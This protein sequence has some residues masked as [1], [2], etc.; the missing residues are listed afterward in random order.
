MEKTKHDLVVEYIEGLA[1]GDKVSVRQLAREMSISEGTVYRAIKDAENQGLVSS[2]PKVGTIRIERVKERSIDS[3]TY[4]ELS[5]IV[6][7]R[8]LSGAS[9]NKI[10]PKK[11]YVV[12]SLEQLKEKNLRP[13]TMIVCEYDA[14]VV[15]YAKKNELA[16]LLTGGSELSQEQVLLASLDENQIVIST[17]YDIFD[18]ISAINQA[19]VQRVQNRELITIADI[20]TTDPYVLHGFDTV[21]DWRELSAQTGH[22]RFP[23]V[24]SNGKLEGVVTSFDVSDA[25]LATYIDDVMTLNPVVVHSDA[26]V[27]YL[28]RLLVLEKVDLVPVVDAEGILL[29]VVGRKDVIEAQQTM[30]KQPHLGDT[31]DYIIMSGFSIVARDPDVII[32]GRVTPYMLDECG[33]LSLG[34]CNVLAANTAGIMLR[35][36][37]N[38]QGQ[39]YQ[40]YT[41]FFQQIGAEEELYVMPML[42]E[43]GDR[44]HVSVRIELADGQLAA[45]SEIDFLVKDK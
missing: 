31:S 1:V 9:H 23:V 18:A 13:S 36:K 41:H 19:I 20:M 6:E 4:D 7:G 26:L 15:A 32:S 34:V 5:K 42:S 43:H 12:T 35:I 28:G 24:D 40:A 29:G 8:F 39:A 38:I 11:F 22:S 25:S 3:L 30:Q 17:P 33:G 10:A 37:K 16:M 14:D 21:S 44:I 45:I 27:S 2:I